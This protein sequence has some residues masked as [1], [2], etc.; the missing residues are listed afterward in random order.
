MFI[1]VFP[2][3]FVEGQGWY[4]NYEKYWWYRY[5][6][7]NDFMKIGPNP[8]ESIPAYLRHRGY[9]TGD[10]VVVG[11]LTWGDATQALGHY[12]AITATEHKILEDNSWPTERAA[13]ENYFSQNAFERLDEHAEAYCRDIHATYP[14]NGN[15]QS[16]DLN[17][18]FIRDDVDENF[19]ARNYLHFNRPGIISS[20]PVVNRPGPFH[21]LHEEFDLGLFGT[22]HNASADSGV[23]SDYYVR[24][25]PSSSL[26]N[27]S[28]TYSW[29]FGPPPI[30]PPVA[31]QYPFEESQDQLT[32]INAGLGLT[33]QLCGGPG[34]NYLGIIGLQSKAADN[35]FRNVN[36]AYSGS[37]PWLIENPTAQNPHCVYGVGPE[38]YWDVSCGDVGGA[39]I[40][41]SAPA[42]AEFTQT[43]TAGYHSAGSFITSAPTSDFLFQASQLPSSANAMFTDNYVAYSRNW[44]TLYLPIPF[45]FAINTSW[46]R[47][48]HHAL[49]N[50][51]QT[52][53]I[54]L[55]Y[56]IIHGGGIDF[57]PN[58]DGQLSYPQ[59]LDFS[60]FCGNFS[61]DDNMSNWGD[62]HYSSQDALS[63][64]SQRGIKNNADFNG[65]DYM[66]L[67]NLYSL[68][69]GDYLQWII[70]PYYTDSFRVN[71]PDANGYGSA[72]KWLKLN[73]LEYLSAIDTIQSN[74][75]L[76]FHG[77]KVI[78]LL[79]GFQTEPGAVFTAYVKDIDCRAEDFHYAEKDGP[80][81]T[82]FIEYN[83]TG[84]SYQSMQR[85]IDTS[86]LWEDT[87]Q[88]VD[89]TLPLQ[90]R[91]NYAET[92]IER[93]KSSGRYEA[94][95]ARLPDS[96]R[97][98]FVLMTSDNHT[99]TV[100]PSTSMAISPNPNPGIFTIS[101][102]EEGKYEASV[103]NSFGQMVYHA[104]FTGNRQ[105]IELGNVPSGT[106]VLKVVSSK[107]SSQAKITI[108]R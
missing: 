40:H 55:I 52:P 31:P 39:S 6:L 42:I 80:E 5:R 92:I 70:N 61:Y 22:T 63:F 93:L 87:V 86:M 25:W 27:S 17:G 29:T 45:N 48:K 35:I 108:A 78:E 72:S 14:N 20:L 1:C 59:M 98:Q 34:G 37:L 30:L 100:L 18:F 95:V 51:F 49:N 13:M 74:A 41:A 62:W 68:V 21:K 65:L 104:S 44:Y 38:F 26:W 47:I 56:K 79:P 73:Y 85:S 83:P 96:I 36:W 60:V 91:I 23:Q 99:N 105:K 15:P 88:D 10:P 82:G 8:G 76:T 54:P 66:E 102:S 12:I 94:F 3:H 81:N 53:H 67:F 24:E 106:Y 77:A 4:R 101:M 90:A 19:V 107:C 9:N 7:V 75:H 57:D 84:R 89:S 64:A 28:Y 50:S 16:S 58:D 33:A 46:N 71:Y 43:T 32:E 11:H 2:F 69:K 103:F 97:Q